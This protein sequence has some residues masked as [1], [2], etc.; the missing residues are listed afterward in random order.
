MPS[1]SAATPRLLAPTRIAQPVKVI[2]T[3]SKKEMMFEGATPLSEVCAKA[4]VKVKY[5][6]KAG[7]C[8][9]CTI[10]VDGECGSIAHA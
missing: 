7:T 2:F 5:Q 10:N 8:A 3:V 1:L 6:C 9:T 4:G